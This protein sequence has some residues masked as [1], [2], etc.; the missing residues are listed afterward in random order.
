MGIRVMQ[1]MQG[2]RRLG[3]TRN[4]LDDSLCGAW[5][6]N[7]R[8]G[9]RPGSRGKLNVETPENPSSNVINK[10]IILQILIGMGF[11]VV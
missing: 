2:K 10:N 6:I 3:G 9:K 7:E 4:E 1:K 11:G 8:G 5:N